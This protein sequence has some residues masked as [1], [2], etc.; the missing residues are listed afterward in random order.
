MDTAPVLVRD[1]MVTQVQCC[2]VDDTL[3]DA[4]DVMLEQG[5]TTLPVVDAR[6]NCVGVIAAVD[7][8]APSEE[9]EEE[10]RAIAAKSGAENSYLAETVETR[11]LAAHVVEDFMTTHV[12]AVAPDT[13]LH[14]AAAEMLT[15]QIHHLVVIAPDDRLVGILSTMD[16]LE[17]FAKQGQTV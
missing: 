1:V 6:Q 15:N 17:V 10:F 7:L 16:I 4:L 11:G 3:R 14:K 8:L 2:S 9:M 5:L 13:E 12:V